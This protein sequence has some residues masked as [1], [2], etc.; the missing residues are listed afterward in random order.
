MDEAEIVS[1][2][3]DFIEEELGKNGFLTYKFYR[4][5]RKCPKF[6]SIR[7]EAIEKK[8]FSFSR[9]EI[10]LCHVL[11]YVD[12]IEIRGPTYPEHYGKFNYEHPE[13]LSIV[14]KYVAGC[15]NRLK[16][17][18]C[19]QGYLIRTESSV[20]YNDGKKR[21]EVLNIPINPS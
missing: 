3:G 21:V 10:Y 4:F 8:Y 2:I 7:V 1:I 16:E 11:V 18:P 6:I 15:Y 13:S 17:Y 14:S 20:A 19:I 5:Y 9:K 12:R